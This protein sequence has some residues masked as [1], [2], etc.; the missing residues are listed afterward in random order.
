MRSPSLLA[1]LFLIYA[2]QAQKFSALTVRTHAPRKPL[3]PASSELFYCLYSAGDIRTAERSCTEKKVAYYILYSA[4]SKRFFDVSQAE[5][6]IN[7][8]FVVSDVASL[9]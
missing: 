7:E 2:G 5:K 4:R 3:C 9:L 8:F 6:N 1:L